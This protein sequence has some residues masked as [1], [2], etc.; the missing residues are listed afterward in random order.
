MPDEIDREITTRRVNSDLNSPVNGYKVSEEQ[1]TR[2]TNDG[3]SSAVIV[4][5]LMFL[6]IGAGAVLYYLSSRP[7]PP[8]IIMPT[9]VGTVRDNKSTII[10]RNNTT[11]RETSPATPQP[12]PRVEII[13]V[14]AATVAPQPVAPA[15][16]MTVTAQPTV[17][18]VPPAQTATPTATP[19]PTAGAGR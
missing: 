6:A 12:T 18:P 16:T 11:I 2:V 14:P 1:R 5:V 7:A 3:S 19:T 17:A 10:E 8:P 15:P 4:G 13:N 9:P